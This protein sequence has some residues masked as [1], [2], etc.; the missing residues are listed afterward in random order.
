[1]SPFSLSVGASDSVSVL[2]EIKSLEVVSLESSQTPGRDE[3]SGMR[4]RRRA[5]SGWLCALSLGQTLFPA[6][7]LWPAC[8]SFLVCQS[9]LC[10][11]GRGT[12]W[13]E[14]D[15]GKVMTAEYWSLISLAENKN[16]EC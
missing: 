9:V 12:V 11:L 2:L 13:M 7:A 3:L 14:S 8:G 4:G 6:G 15:A 10:N 1:M 5:G 16:T